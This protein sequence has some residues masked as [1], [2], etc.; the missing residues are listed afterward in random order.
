MTNFPPLTISLLAQISDQDLQSN[1]LNHV[2]QTDEVA[3][4]LAQIEDKDLALK[5]INLALEV[6]LILGSKLTSSSSPEVQ[7]VIVEQI[8]RL[9]IP[10]ALK[11]ELWHQTKSKSALPHLQS[12]FF[13]KLH[14]QDAGYDLTESSIAAIIDIDPEQ[15]IILLRESQYDSRFSARAALL[16][17]KIAPSEAIKLLAGLLNKPHFTSDWDGKHLAMQAL[18]DIGTDEAINKIREFLADRCYWSESAYIHGLGIVAEPAMVDHLVY[19]LS[20]PEDTDDL[21]LYAIEALECV[22]EK[23]FD[24]LHR[25]LY[26]LKFDEDRCYVFHKILEILFKWDYERTMISLE[27]AIQSY[28]PTV[29]VRAAMALSSSY[30]LI[31]DRNILTLLSTLAS[32]ETCK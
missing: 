27:G 15:A 31:A 7:A 24:C 13:L 32:S 4:L 1:Y 12:I 23:M 29:R 19:L 30:I 6:D 16:L 22:G 21:C 28:D 9:E 3:S 5:V 11:L 17:A 18:G 10:I 14:Y 20:Q 8:D 2:D 25:A 26:W